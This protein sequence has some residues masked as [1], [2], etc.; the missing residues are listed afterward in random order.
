MAKGASK[1]GKGGGGS[2]Q[3]A[4][5]PNKAF[6]KNDPTTWAVGTEVTWQDSDLYAGEGRGGT[7]TYQMEGVI[8]EVH[9]NHLVI[10]DDIG[11]SNW[12]DLDE[13]KYTAKSSAT[14][15][16]PTSQVKVATKGTAPTGFGNYGF[17]INGKKIWFSG[18]F[19][20]ARQKAINYAAAKGVR[21]IS[22]Q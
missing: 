2:V 21:N 13:T 16:I 20:Q 8:T 12:V 11:V 3:Q 4:V 14:K 19:D 6:S 5:N 15:A 7:R 22:L 18:E 1:V 9:P 17:V 10:T